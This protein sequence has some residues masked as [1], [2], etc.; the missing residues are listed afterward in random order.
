MNFKKFLIGLLVAFGLPWVFAVAIPYARM[1]KLPPVEFI[2]EIDG[3]TGYYEFARSGRTDG[4]SIYGANGCNQCHTQ[5]IRPSYAGSEIHRD[6]WA[7]LP[8]VPADEIPDTRRE[9]N[10]FDYVGEDF[11]FVG[12]TRIGPDLSNVAIRVSQYSQEAEITPTEWLMKHLYNPRDID[13]LSSCPPSRFMFKGSVDKPRSEAKAL[14][15]YLLSLQKNDAI[16]ASQN[17]RQLSAQ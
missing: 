10:P 8:A 7:G 6:N 12:Q 15:A 11:A 5:L 17:P 2:E 9:T 4:A 1:A 3:K 16:P 14:V 13:Y